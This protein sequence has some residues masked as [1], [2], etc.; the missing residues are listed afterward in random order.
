MNVFWVF[1]TA[2]AYKLDKHLMELKLRNKSLL[3]SQLNLKARESKCLSSTDY[4]MRLPSQVVDLHA[5]S[6]R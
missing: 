5:S 4:I 3:S 2:Y 6:V 1:L